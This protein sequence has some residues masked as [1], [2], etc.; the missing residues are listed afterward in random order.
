MPKNSKASFFW[1]FIVILLLGASIF[2]AYGTYQSGNVIAKYRTYLKKNKETSVQW[3]E[4]TPLNINNHF[5]CST[6][7]SPDEGLVTFKI[8]NIKNR[9]QREFI[10]HHDTLI[11]MKSLRREGNELVVIID[12]NGDGI[13]EQQEIYDTNDNSLKIKYDISVKNMPNF[14]EQE[15]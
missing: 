15:P 13:P 4:W 3:S 7:T 5:E 11:G 6:A 10:F 9:N 1:P 2:L 14:T 8:R 12:S